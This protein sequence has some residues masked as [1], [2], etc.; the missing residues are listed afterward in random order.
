HFGT[1]LASAHSWLE[2][3]ALLR[4][5]ELAG[6]A[7]W[8]VWMLAAASVVLVVGLVL[9]RPSHAV[10]NSAS[11]SRPVGVATG[12]PSPSGVPPTAAATAAREIPAAPLPL[13]AV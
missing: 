9:S 10:V 13:A 11:N 3:P 2:Q 5:H 8:E 4:L 6:A 12:A 7:P 1:I